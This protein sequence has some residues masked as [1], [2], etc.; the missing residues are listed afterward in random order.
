[1]GATKME[2][3]FLLKIHNGLKDAK[4]YYEAT[5][6]NWKISEKGWNQLYILLVSIEEK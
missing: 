5:R 1:M 2:E 4:N 3:L 6:G